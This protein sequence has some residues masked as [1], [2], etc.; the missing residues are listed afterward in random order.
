MARTLK[1]W[2]GRI[3][4]LE[5][6]KDPKWENQSPSAGMC[7][8]AAYSRQDANRIIEEYTGIAPPPNETKVYFDQGPWG[9]GMKGIEPTERGIWIAFGAKADRAAPVKVY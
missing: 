8:I 7:F 2:K 1:F 5:N 9:I 4:H 6:P 3:T